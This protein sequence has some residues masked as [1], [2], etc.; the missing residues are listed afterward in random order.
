MRFSILLTCA[1]FVKLGLAGYI[2]KDDYPIANFFSLFSFNTGP[3]STTLG[4]TNY[5]SRSDAQT[6]GLINTNNNQVYMGVDYSNI[7]A[8]PGRKSVRIESLK[9]YTHALIIVDLAHM[10]GGI[11]ATWPAFWTYGPDWPNS[12]EIDIL[13]GVNANNQNSMTL[14]TRPGCF[15]D[16]QTQSTDS[17]TV[18]TDCTG[19]GNQGCGN[20][21]HSPATYGAD[22]NAQGGGIYATEWTSAAIKIWFWANGTGPSDIHGGSPDPSTWGRP[23]ALFHGGCDIDTFFR[24]HKIVFDTTFCGVWAGQVWST[25]PCASKASSCEA[26]VRDNP[27][28][29][30]DAYWTVNSLQVYQDDEISVSSAPVAKESQSS[31]ETA[32]APVATVAVYPV[33]TLMSTSTISMAG[34]ATTTASFIKHCNSTGPRPAWEVCM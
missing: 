32:E 8:G 29:F 27:S 4:Y 9:T 2:L 10:P 17:T 28:A 31:S 18:T 11:C 34:A 24:D 23:L 30:E 13:E 15:I 3:D 22:F 20:L 21:A 12:G 26:Y 6:E 33:T 25:S 1:G 19:T 5:L 7:A 16:N 14:H